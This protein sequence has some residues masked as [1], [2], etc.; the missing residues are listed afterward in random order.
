MGKVEERARKTPQPQ[1]GHSLLPAL[2][3]AGRHQPRPSKPLQHVGMIRRR[4]LL[5]KDELKELSV[6]LGSANLAREPAR[7]ALVRMCNTET[8]CGTGSR[9][10]EIR[11][12]IMPEKNR[13]GLSNGQLATQLLV[14]QPRSGSGLLR[15]EGE[16][17]QFVPKSSEASP[18]ELSDQEW[19][20]RTGETCSI[21]SPIPH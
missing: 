2:H 21:N 9:S 15:S 14:P 18:G 16:P 4:R 11:S 1:L 10:L 20:I 8:Q 17:S 6:R 3:D 7:R 13:I 5:S 19:E 12:S